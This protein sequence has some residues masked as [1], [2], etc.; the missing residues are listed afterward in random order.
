MI[1][2]MMESKDAS[3]DSMLFIPTMPLRGSRDCDSELLDDEDDEEG[4]V[5][6]EPE[7]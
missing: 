7:V 2:P 4:P 6:E 5:D 3:K 1:I